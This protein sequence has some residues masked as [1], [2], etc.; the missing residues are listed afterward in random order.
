VGAT[1]ADLVYF[2]GIGSNLADPAAQVQG[3]IAALTQRYTLREESSLYE[4]PAWGITDQPA[5]INAVVKLETPLQP[6]QLLLELKQLEEGL[7]RQPTS[8]WGPRIIDL[9]I[10]LC[11]PKIH[12]GERVTVPHPRLH[13]RAF[14]LIPLLEIDP[15]AEHPVLR[16]TLKECLARLDPNEVGGVRRIDRPR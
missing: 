5:F 8:H 11:G 2:I 15:A 7:G 13:E 4:T 12:Q 16:T 6:E 3:A 14:A 9:D 10:L 1:L